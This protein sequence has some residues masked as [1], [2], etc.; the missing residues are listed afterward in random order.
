MAYG[1]ESDK[2]AVSTKGTSYDP[3]KFFET[4]NGNIMPKG[5]EITADVAKDYQL[6]GVA[7]KRLRKEIREAIKDFTKQGEDA[8]PALDVM[9]AV[10]LQQLGTGEMEEALKTANMIAEFETPKLSRREVEQRNI[11]VN[12]MS[13]EDIEEEL[14]DVHLKLVSN[15]KDS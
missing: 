3:D 9:K 11:E 12:E 15:S 13:T 4:P 14:S 6:R 1:N 10:M 8:P 7:T 5:K 2:T